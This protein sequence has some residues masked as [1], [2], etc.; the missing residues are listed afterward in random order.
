MNNPSTLNLLCYLNYNLGFHG[1]EM[2]LHSNI[3]QCICFLSIEINRR[4]ALT[5]TC[6]LLLQ[7]QKVLPK[8]NFPQAE[9]GCAVNNCLAILLQ[10]SPLVSLLRSR[11][12]GS[13]VSFDFVTMNA[14][15]IHQKPFCVSF[16]AVSDLLGNSGHT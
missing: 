12:D 2:Q 16:T 5:L 7:A 11:M 13:W 10:S 8:E 9:L 1:F 15:T 3:A 14:I 6:A 4:F